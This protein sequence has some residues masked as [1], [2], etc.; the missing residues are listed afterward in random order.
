MRAPALIIVGRLRKAH[1]VR[2]DIVV[3]PITD[4]PAEVFTAGRRLFAGT[5]TGDPA[6]DRTELTIISARPMRNG[7][8]LV[9]FDTIA[10][11]TQAEQWRDRYLLSPAS[12]LRPP[13]EHEVYYHELVGMRVELSSGEP[14][15]EIVQIYELPQG[16]M[17]DVRRRDRTVVLPFREELV[18]AVDPAGR[19]IVMT[20]PQGLLE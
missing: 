20:L 15:G 4:A 13:E 6:P 7:A 11:R 12:E 16:L 2:G 18:E 17:L 19:R 8:F 5:V 14:V 9:R 1:G 10:D 3:E